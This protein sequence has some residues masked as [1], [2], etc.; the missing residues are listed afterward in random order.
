MSKKSSGNNNLPSLSNSFKP[1]TLS[2]NNKGN[3]SVKCSVTSSDTKI[4]V[5]TFSSDR[6]NCNVN[7]NS[8]TSVG[9]YISSDSHSGGATKGGEGVGVG[10]NIGFKFGK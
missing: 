1:P 9:G 5:T 10:L 8:K 4:G 6:L 2:I 3:S 7:I